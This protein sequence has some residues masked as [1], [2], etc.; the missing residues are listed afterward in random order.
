MT[1]GQ[2]LWC[3]SGAVDVHLGAQT[4]NLIAGD[5]L[6]A[7]GHPT[8]TAG[9]GDL[10]L[11]LGAPVLPERRPARRI[12]L[13]PQW[14]QRM[15]H[16]YSRHLFGEP[17]PSAMILAL[18]DEKAATPPL[19][20]SAAARA[21]ARMLVEDP[22]VPDNLADLAARQGVT[23]RTLQ[24]QFLR[25]TGHT[26]SQWRSAHRVSVA[27]RL[28]A[29]EFRIPVVTDL[30]GFSATSSLTRAFRRH[31]GSPPSAHTTATP[32]PAIPARTIHAEPG[33][34]RQL[35]VHSGTA[36]VTTPGFCRFI[37]PGESATIPAGGPTRIDVAAGSV[38]LPVP[39]GTGDVDLAT[40]V[41]LHRDQEE[42]CLSGNQ[43]DLR[44]VVP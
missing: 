13:G 14:R 9:P 28:L 43:T 1:S 25:E 42:I 16:E 27:A 22:A 39:V 41:R 5:L 7:P 35:W 34:D 29:H 4:F 44:C 12:H 2:L 18:L 36:T 30:V 31:T 19:P 20:S 8:W 37:G 11:D 6:L 32:V 40:V 10:L 24:R 38:V 33:R 17:E 23:A 15:I 3:H 26:F 21:V